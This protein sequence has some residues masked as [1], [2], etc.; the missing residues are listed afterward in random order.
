MW[1]EHLQVLEIFLACDDQWR[2]GPNGLLGLDLGVVLQF[3]DLY[4]VE[5]KRQLMAD[6]RFITNRVRELVNNKQEG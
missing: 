5:N 3:C 1:P 4:N 6:L 2:T